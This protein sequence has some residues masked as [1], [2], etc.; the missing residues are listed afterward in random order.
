T[1]VETMTALCKDTTACANFS[2]TRIPLV[3]MTVD[4]NTRL[5][6]P[7]SEGPIWEALLAATAL[8]GL[9]PPFERDGQRLVDGLCMVPVPTGAVTAAGAD[10]TLALNIMGRDMLSAW[11]GEEPPEPPQPRTGSR[12]LETLLDVIDLAQL[13]SSERHTALADVPVTPVFGP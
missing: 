3:V 2:D 13:D 9:F 11:P 7:I 8:P 1:G 12:I 10:I 6:V 4:L 5:P